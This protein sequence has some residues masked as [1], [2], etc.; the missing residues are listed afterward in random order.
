MQF[1][2]AIRSS[3]G[4]RSKN[5]DDADHF[6]HDGLAGWVLADGLGGHRGGGL[7]SSLAT[8]AVVE[9]CEEC[10]RVT[11]D[12]VQRA[13]QAAQDLLHERQR[14]HL[15]YSQMR[16]T[17]VLLLA[18]PETNTALWGHVG[19][20]R[21]YHFREGEI[22]AR[23]KDHSAV[24]AL[25]DAGELEPDEMRDHSMGHRITRS[26]GDSGEA[27]PEVAES[28]AALQPGDAFLLC[29]DGFWE[30]VPEERMLDVLDGAASPDDWI[31]EMAT[32]I[33]DTAEEGH[34]NYTAVAV[35]AEAS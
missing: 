9:A 21:L 20:S 23:T 6:I 32:Y 26:L 18:D 3:S 28:A 1:A 2:T 4:G 25:V 29:S 31:D 11:G 22:A 15:E 12:A 24:Q 19:D 34:D 7:A 5:Q 27:N 8:R 30:G 10:D 33:E 16:T 14:E 17:L 13:A 35:F